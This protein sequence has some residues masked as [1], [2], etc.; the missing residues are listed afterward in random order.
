MSCLHGESGL[1]DHIFAMIKSDDNSIMT[2][3]VE[4]VCNASQDAL[5]VPSPV[6][7]TRVSVMTASIRLKVYQTGFDG[8]TS[9]VINL[10]GIRML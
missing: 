10:R 1:T 4:G 5:Q 3:M 6:A 7:T 8:R 2:S 9:E